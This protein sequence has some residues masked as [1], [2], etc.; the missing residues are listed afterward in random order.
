MRCWNGFRVLQNRS[1]VRDISAEDLNRFIVD[2]MKNQHM[3]ANTVIHNV[4]II[5]QFFKRQGRPNITRELHLPGGSRPFPCEYREQ[6]L[7]RFFAACNEREQV[8]FSTFLMTGL[9]RTGSG[10]SWLDRH[11]L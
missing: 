9:Q 5:A 10:P 4:I 7:A 3:A 6:D 8:L 1:T 2:L 11:Q